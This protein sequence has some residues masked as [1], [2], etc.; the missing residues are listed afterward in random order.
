MAKI[1]LVTV[2]FNSNEVLEGFI[3]SL[4]IQSF[5][6][7][8]LYLIDNTPSDES[9][10]YLNDL[11]EKYAIKNYSHIKNDSNVGVAKGNNQGIELSRK[12]GTTY[13]LLLNND[14]EFEQ[15]DFLLQMYERA[16]RENEMMIIPKIYFWDNRKIWMAGGRF[17]TLRG[18]TFHEGEGE[19][20][21]EKYCQDKYFDYAPTCFMLINNKLFDEIGVMD[22]SYFVYFD[23]TDFIYRAY[24]K[25]YNILMMHSLHVLHKVSSST[26]GS[27]SP[28]TIYYGTRN[29]IYF[30]R[31]NFKGFN[32]LKALAFT[33][34]TRII[35]HFEYDAVRKEKMWKG[36]SEGFKM[37]TQ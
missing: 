7:Y 4:S 20:D 16:Q 5:Q 17:S 8:H 22:E 12:S 15:A 21:S 1:G 35:K 9:D 23:D 14:I 6:D 24:K 25:G 27:E 28:F 2:L 29:R 37:N 32:F 30:I 18:I 26:G 11:L 19:D 36:F 10:K 3:K 31:K 34:S 33:I 13:T